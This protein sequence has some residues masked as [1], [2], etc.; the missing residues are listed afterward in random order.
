MLGNAR[1][2]KIVYIT[3][4]FWYFVETQF[5]WLIVGNPWH[6]VFHLVYNEEVATQAP[7]SSKSKGRFG[8]M[9]LSAA[10]KEHADT[11]PMNS[12]AMNRTGGRSFRQ[13]PPC[14]IIKLECI[15]MMLEWCL[16][17]CGLLNLHC[18]GCGSGA[19]LRKKWSL[20]GPSPPS[21]KK[22]MPTPFWYILKQWTEHRAAAF[23]SS[24]PVASIKL[25]VWAWCWHDGGT[26][27]EKSFIWM[28]ELIKQHRGSPQQRIWGTKQF[29]NNHLGLMFG[30]P[31]AW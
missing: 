27:G 26:T 15:G 31:G 5:F 22:T 30:V 13:R 9:W 12:K 14:G 6:G 23:G 1:T 29:Q 21:P 8:N 17:L 18:N 19:P 20:R 24:P 7:Q 4:D 10:K 11:M 28:T 25:N 2:C 3:C 16:K